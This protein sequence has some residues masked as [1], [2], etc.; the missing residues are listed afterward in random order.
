MSIP[1]RILTPNMPEYRCA[2]IRRPG[3][4]HKTLVIP[5]LLPGAEP[6]MHM[7]M[8]TVSSVTG[9]SLNDIKS[10]RRAR[11]LVRARTIFYWLARKITSKSLPQIGKACGNRD[12][13]TVM[14]GL[15]KVDINRAAFE[16]DLTRTVSIIFQRG[17]GQ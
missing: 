1:P 9:I 12:H 15:L 8:A 10:P 14:H 2:I 4:H 7:I 11:E 3:D 6:S 5:A 13:S 16:P 17:G